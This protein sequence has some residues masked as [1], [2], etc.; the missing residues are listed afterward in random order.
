LPRA[1][2]GDSR[3]FKPSASSLAVSKPKTV[4]PRLPV[5]PPLVSGP[6]PAV[7]IGPG[8]PAGKREAT[9]HGLGAAAWRRLRQT[10]EALIPRAKPTLLT[11]PRAET[12]GGGE[13]VGKPRVLAPEARRA[14]QGD[15]PKMVMLPRD[16]EGKRAV[17]LIHTPSRVRF[18][19][20]TWVFGKG[21]CHVSRFAQYCSLH[22]SALTLTAIAVDRHQ[23][24]M[25]PLKPRISV[26]RGVVYVAVIWTMATVFSLPHAICQ[27]LFT[28]KYSEDTV[29]SLCLPDFPEPADLFWKCLDWAT[30]VLLYILPLLVISVAYAR[31]AKKLWLC[32]AIGDVTTE[33]YLALRRKKKTTVKMLVLVVVLFALCWFPLNCYVLLLSSAVIRANNALYFAFHWFAM[34]SACYNP[35]IYCWLNESFRA[36]LK[37]LLS[38]CPRPAKPQGARPPSPAPSFRVAWAERGDSRRAPPAGRSP[39]PSP[40]LPGKTDLAAVEPV[41]VLS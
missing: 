14:A 21:M 2:T 3:A 4:A 37:A 7:G 10:Q 6:R 35:F 32:G 27:K 5:A 11:D 24:I 20:S 26:A 40:R 16:L 34:S 19:N 15:V 1:R 17:T 33:Q 22:V 31:V 13:L 38:V 29:R 30:F 36:E 25:H 9:E 39:P 8:R 28:F 12:P 41:V 18:V 23:V